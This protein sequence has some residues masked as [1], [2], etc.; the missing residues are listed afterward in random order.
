MVEACH[1]KKYFRGLVFPELNLR[2]RGGGVDASLSMA[3]KKK[4]LQIDLLKKS[5]T[6]RCVPP[7]L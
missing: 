2:M 4:D 6:S 3:S 5:P 7:K 1:R